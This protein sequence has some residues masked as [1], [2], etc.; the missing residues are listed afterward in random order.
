MTAAVWKRQAFPGAIALALIPLL[1]PY[2]RFGW[3]HPGPLLY[4]RGTVRA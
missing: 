4:R 2:S 3:L 1:G